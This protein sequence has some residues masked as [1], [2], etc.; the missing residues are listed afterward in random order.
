MPPC[1][2][3]HTHKRTLRAVLTLQT[4]VTRHRSCTAPRL[5]GV[6]VLQWSEA[7]QASRGFPGHLSQPH[8]SVFSLGAQPIHD[9]PT[10][11]LSQRQKKQDQKI[12]RVRAQGGEGP[13]GPGGRVPPPTP[14]PLQATS[15]QL[16]GEVRGRPGRR[17]HPHLGQ[18]P[19]APPP[20]ATPTHVGLLSV[21][22]HL[23]RGRGYTL[24]I[25]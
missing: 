21:S 10:E 12:R 17:L 23:C 18:S 1:T 2:A 8:R 7:G 22:L 24:S 14:S 9:H 5:A 15:S 6:K 19:E 16:L 20:A 13:E 25:C 3:F 11:S 4:K